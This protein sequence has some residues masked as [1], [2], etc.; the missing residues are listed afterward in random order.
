M[1]ENLFLYGNSKRIDLHGLTKEEARAELLHL[2]NSLDASVDCVIVIHGYSKGS[3]LKNMVRKEFSHE[4][5]EKLVFVD[6]GVTAIKIKK[7]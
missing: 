6:A 5:I 4:L 7:L 1:I 2:F 3:V